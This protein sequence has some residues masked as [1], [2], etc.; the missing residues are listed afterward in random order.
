M[1]LNIDYDMA[2]SVSEFMYDNAEKYGLDKDEM[3]VLGYI[4]QI[5]KISNTE[6]YAHAGG[7]ILYKQGFKYSNIVASHNMTPE[8]YCKMHLVDEPPIEMILLWKGIINYIKS[9]EPYN[10]GGN[11][12][13]IVNPNITGTQKSIYVSIMNYLYEWDED[14]RRKN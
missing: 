5:G 3:F 7:V 8:E 2:N 11:S 6:D 12:E 1:K 13:D 9:K 14:W 4:F 10:F